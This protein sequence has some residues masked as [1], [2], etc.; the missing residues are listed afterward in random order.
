MKKEITDKELRLFYERMMPN[1]RFRVYVTLQNQLNKVCNQFDESD[2]D[3]TGED[4][5][6][7]NFLAFVK[8]VKD[9]MTNMDDIMSKLDP[10][11]AAQIKKEQTE[12][13]ALT[14]EAMI[15]KG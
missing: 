4:D 2:I 7:K 9:L 14:L 8:T 3:I 5:V 12:A 6:F 1:P 10:E 11:K 13:G 15:K